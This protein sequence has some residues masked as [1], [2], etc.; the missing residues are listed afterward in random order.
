MTDEVAERD[1]FALDVSIR[2]LRLNWTDKAACRGL[3]PNMF[4]LDVGQSAEP[5]KKVCA[6]C[7]V[8]DACLDFG[9]RTMASGVHGGVVLVRGH[10][11]KPRKK[12]T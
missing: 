1:V 11:S 6:Q 3:N 7:S 8:T 9:M 4:V 12:K 10:P 5:A 2:A